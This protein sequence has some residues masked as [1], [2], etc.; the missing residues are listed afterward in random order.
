MATTFVKVT[1]RLESA[2]QAALKHYAIDKGLKVERVFNAAV[3]D[4]LMR[5]KRIRRAA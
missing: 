5:K 4:Y 2:L 3:H 1:T